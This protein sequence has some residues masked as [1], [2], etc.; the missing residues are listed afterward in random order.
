MT[1]RELRNLRPLQLGLVALLGLVLPLPAEPFDLPPLAMQVNDFAAVLKSSYS[2]DL[3]RRLTRFHQKTGYAIY[4]VLM[5]GDYNQSLAG[6]AGEVFELNL[7]KEGFC[8][9]CTAANRSTKRPSGN[10]DQ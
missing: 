10:R 4:I 6:I 3:N 1:Y 9:N 8:W 7:G 2:A 5:A